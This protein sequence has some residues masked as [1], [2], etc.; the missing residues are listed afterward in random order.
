LGPT[1][2]ET[3]PTEIVLLATTAPRQPIAGLV[4][5]VVSVT[6]GSWK[7]LTPICRPMTAG[8]EFT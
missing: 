8:K 3:G 2:W 7:S 5:V 6:V 4:T 1:G